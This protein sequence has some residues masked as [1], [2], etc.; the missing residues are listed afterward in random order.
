MYMMLQLIAHIAEEKKNLKLKSSTPKCSN[1]SDFI[2]SYYIIFG[3]Q[4]QHKNQQRKRPPLTHC[5]GLEETL[6]PP[7]SQPLQQIPEEIPCEYWCLLISEVRCAKI[8]NSTLIINKIS[9]LHRR[10]LYPY[11]VT[12]VRNISCQTTQVK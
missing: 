4:L 9:L 1:K 2:F 11:W 6:L 7:L 5:W 3:N 10:I 12:L 8:I